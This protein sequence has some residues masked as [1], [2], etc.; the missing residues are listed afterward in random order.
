MHLRIL[1]CKKIILV[2]VC[3]DYNVCISGMLLLFT[4]ILDSF[5]CFLVHN[6]HKISMLPDIF[7]LLNDEM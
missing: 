6:F 3:V 7:V 5:C 4:S 1:V 2:V